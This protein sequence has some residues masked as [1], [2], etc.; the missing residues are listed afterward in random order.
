[1]QAKVYRFIFINKQSNH[2]STFIRNVIYEKDDKFNIGNNTLHG[3][4]GSFFCSQC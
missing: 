2:I 3:V 1:M 4:N